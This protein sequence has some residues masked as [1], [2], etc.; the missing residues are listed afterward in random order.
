MKGKKELN[1]KFRLH[2]TLG[3]LDIAEHEPGKEKKLS[4]DRA[5][6][7]VLMVR[8][9]LGA[10][11]LFAVFLKQQVDKGFGSLQARFTLCRALLLLL[12]IL[13]LSVL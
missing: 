6:T 12:P 9:R 7:F 3:I 13:L 5:L 2:F 10:T 11:L 8:R 1:Q 4:C